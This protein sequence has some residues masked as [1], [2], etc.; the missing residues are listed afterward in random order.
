MKN[1]LLFP[2]KVMKWGLWLIPGTFVAVVAACIGMGVTA[3]SD[4]PLSIILNRFI[5]LIGTFGVCG[6]TL[7]IFLI[8]FSKE[9]EEDEMISD[10]RIK[11]IGIAAIIALFIYLFGNL[12]ISIM[13]FYNFDF[14][15]IDAAVDSEDIT[16]I[17]N[18]VEGQVKSFYRLRINLYRLVTPTML[19]IYYEIVFRIKLYIARKELRDE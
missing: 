9:K 19:F 8:A 3:S 12:C 11:S 15:F 10:M 14:S 6:F 17:Q 16:E 13:E 18:I 2:H 5:P 4:V 1:N 7:A